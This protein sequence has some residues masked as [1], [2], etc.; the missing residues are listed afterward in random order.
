[1]LLISCMFLY[2][3]VQKKKKERKFSCMFINLI[4]LFSCFMWLLTGHTFFILK[5]GVHDIFQGSPDRPWHEDEPRVNK[6]VFI[7]K[8]LDKQEIEKGFKACI[9]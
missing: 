8:N 1:M 9:L 7:G 2:S 6:I 4:N 5:Q 3:Y